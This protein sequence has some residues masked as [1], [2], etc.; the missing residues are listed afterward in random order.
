MQV[1]RSSKDYYFIG[2]IFNRKV[3]RSILEQVNYGLL[4]L[5]VKNG[6]I[7]LITLKQTLLWFI[8]TKMVYI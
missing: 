4:Q 5:C 1:F 6:T 3:K 8:H 7:L 2:L